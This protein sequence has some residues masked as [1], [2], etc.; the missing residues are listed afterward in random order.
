MAAQ[1]AANPAQCAGTL[2][3]VRS[4]FAGVSQSREGKAE[5][6]LLR[7]SL[8]NNNLTFLNIKRV[9]GA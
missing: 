9:L 5:C 4:E 1:S 6:D 7:P 3:R 8:A 2:A